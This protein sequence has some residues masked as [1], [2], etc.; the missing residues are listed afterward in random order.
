MG[1]KMIRKWEVLEGYKFILYQLILEV[2]SIA[3]YT[4]INF[5]LLLYL[6]LLRPSLRICISISADPSS[7]G[8]SKE[9]SGHTSKYRKNSTA[10]EFLK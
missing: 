8:L 4:C 9:I 1:Q 6:W 3:K 7:P 5:L 2:M 10:N